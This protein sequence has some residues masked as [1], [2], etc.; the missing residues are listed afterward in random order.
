MS[1]TAYDAC[2]EN[3]FADAHRD[4]WEGLG[5]ATWAEAEGTVGDGGG[6]YAEN[7]GS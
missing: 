2:A 5:R 6:A 4:L 1:N 7:A 3:T